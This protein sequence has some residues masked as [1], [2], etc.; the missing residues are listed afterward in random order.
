MGKGTKNSGFSFRF[1]ALVGFK[2]EKLKSLLE[3]YLC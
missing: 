1:L 3:K 2:N